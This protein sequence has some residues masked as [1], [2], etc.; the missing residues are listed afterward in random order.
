MWVNFL[1]KYQNL[2]HSKS[3]KTQN[4]V[5]AAKEIVRKMFGAKFYVKKN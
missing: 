3:G 1:K 2:F 5:G 4:K